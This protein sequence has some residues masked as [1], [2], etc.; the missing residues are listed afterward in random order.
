MIYGAIIGDIIGSRFEFK[1]NL[2]I[3]KNFTMFDSKCKVTDDSIMTIAVAKA[4]IDSINIVDEDKIK[5]KLIYYVTLHSAKN[6][7]P[8]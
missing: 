6:R 4:M 2:N 3:H 5:D 7:V 1:H 8:S